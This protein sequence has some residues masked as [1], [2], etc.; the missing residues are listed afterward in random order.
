MEA[1][2]EGQEVVL[3]EPRP[4]RPFKSSEEYL[5]AMKED[6]AEW[7][8]RLYHPQLNID[9]DNFMDVLEDGVALCKHANNVRRTAM[10][11]KEKLEQQDSQRRR[12]FSTHLD[13]PDRDILFR[14]EVKPK[15]FFARDNVHNFIQ[16]CR[17]L[18]IYECLLFETDDLVLRK[19]EK[20]FILCLLEV[21]RRGANFGMPAPVLVQ[22]EK[23]I[24]REIAKEGNL[25]NGNE[26][27]EEDMELIEYGPQAQIV[28]ND[29][30]SLDEMVRDL[31]ENCSCPTQFPMIRVSEGKYRIGDTKMLIF[32]R[33][34]RNHVMVRVGGGWDTLSHYLEKHDP[35]RC[36]AGH[37]TPITSKLSVSQNSR[38]TTQMEV[39]YERGTS[40]PNSRRSSGASV[41]GT[42]LSR[43]NSMTGTSILPYSSCDSSAEASPNRFHAR[44]RSPSPS[45][46]HYSS[47]TLGSSPI[48]QR[49][50][51]ARYSVNNSCNYGQP[52]YQQEN[53]KVIPTLQGNADSIES[54]ESLPGKRIWSPGYRRSPS[55]GNTQQPKLSRLQDDHFGN[56]ANRTKTSS[57]N[58]TDSSSEISDEGY[59]TGIGAGDVKS[60][61]LDERPDSSCTQVSQSSSLE[62]GVSSAGPLDDT[63]PVG[64]NYKQEKQENKYNYS[65]IPLLG[66]LRNMGKRANSHYS[67]ES[68]SSSRKSSLDSEYRLPLQSNGT[69]T[70]P[71][72][73]NLGFRREA[74]GRHSL[75]TRSSTTDGDKLT[76]RNNISIGDPVPKNTFTWS[77]RNRRQR[78]SIQTEATFIGNR[79]PV[80]GSS[81]RSRSVNSAAS[82]EHSR[83]S[84]TSPSSRRRNIFVA[85][86]GYGAPTSPEIKP[87]PNLKL[88]KPSQ[89]K[90]QSNSPLQSD[91]SKISPL[92]R[93][94]LKDVELDNDASIL[95]KM[96]EIVNQYKARVESILAAEGKT[97][98]ED[99]TAN[100]TP[101]ASNK[102]SEQQKEDPAQRKVK[103][104]TSKLTRRNSLD[105]SLS[106]LPTRMFVSPRKDVVSQSPSKIPMPRFYRPKEDMRNPCLV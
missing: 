77:G 38:G 54:D 19:N 63:D 98:N 69:S 100:V 89:S 87:I 4:F 53:N 103:N 17:L 7:L 30:R 67:T 3:M 105:S 11:Y 41:T 16:W 25:E 27:D 13:I 94:M 35:C 47:G 34:L 15:S 55:V 9:F 84:S 91:P 70:S 46:R 86:S 26:Y 60:E 31:V 20:S 22:F 81:Y 50:G 85:S 78:P 29:L 33:V 76:V 97:L 23:E 5:V 79:N 48:F 14:S 2:C 75:R 95:K 62:S 40:P 96:E 6:L 72:L 51:S 106:H 28:T 52:A 99:Y 88:Q 39:S 56:K 32:V 10:A 8:H 64:N 71:T 45:I 49:S 80:P 59:R 93:N 1:D 44:H 61:E 65:K 36:R 58:N 83:A 82:R 66:S 18:G 102:I 12:K 37:R 42:T 101:L 104:G 21:A 43:K 73:T 68:V 90:Q 57:I 74:F 92:L 24:D